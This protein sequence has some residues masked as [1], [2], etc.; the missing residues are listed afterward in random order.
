MKELGNFIE[1]RWEAPGENFIGGI[2]PSSEEG[3]W[4]APDTDV[5]D[6]ARAVGAANAAKASWSATPAPERGELLRRAASIVASRSDELAG[7]ITADMG[8]TLAEARGEVGEVFSYLHYA[9]GW[10]TQGSGQVVPSAISGRRAWTEREPLG[11]VA[12][13]TPWN[14]PACIPV[15]KLAG[16]LVT[17]N[18]AVWKPASATSGTAS[19]LTSMFAQAGFPDGVINLIHGAGGVAGNALVDNKRVK[20]V[21]FTGSTSVGRG[22]AASTAGRGARSV[23]EMGGKNAALVFED[24]DLAHAAAAIVEGAFATTGQRCTATSRVIVQRAVAQELTE[25]V[26]KGAES[27]RVGD[28]T[29][30]DTDIGPM[31]SEEARRDLARALAEVR[32]RGGKLLCGGLVPNEQPRGFFFSPTVVA[33]VAPEDPIATEELFGPVTVILPVDDRDE[34]LTTA[35]ATDYG[36][37]ASVFTSDLEA[38]FAAI[39][40]LDVGMVLVNDSTVAAETHLPFGGRKASGFGGRDT[41]TESFEAYTELKTVFL[42]WRY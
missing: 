42:K 22:I 34:A 37:T 11:V 31:V 7:Q 13:I 14:F 6:V 40:S 38:A 35:N 28:P 24:A 17:G 29:A 21:T 2:N 3:I 5:R 4:R 30:E 18:T 41:G 8:K 23:L 10:G 1:G 19:V 16:A 26:V 15:W 32:E 12:V 9:A 20:A 33:G 25:R 27:L 39:G 36:L